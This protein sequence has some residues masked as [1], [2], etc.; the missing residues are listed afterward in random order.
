MSRKIIYIKNPKSGSNFRTLGGSGGGISTPSA[1]KDA[2]GAIIGAVVNAPTG[3]ARN[4]LPISG[5]TTGAYATLLTKIPGQAS[6]ADYNRSLQPFNDFFDAA[7]PN[8]ITGAVSWS[9]FVEF[10]FTDTRT[11]P[12]LEG[13]VKQPI[14]FGAF[15]G[16]L[17]SVFDFQ[18]PQEST[19]FIGQINESGNIVPQE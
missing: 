14:A 15:S 11:D 6:L 19:H 16:G 8:P 18:R 1:P 17:A 9:T 13:V 5:A 12:I 3:G 4:K 2:F 10:M 7:F